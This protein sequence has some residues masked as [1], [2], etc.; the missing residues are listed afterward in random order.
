MQCSNQRTA[1]IGGKQAFMLFMAGDKIPAHG[2]QSW[3]N[4]G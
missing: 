1:Q 4:H 2:Y 3:K